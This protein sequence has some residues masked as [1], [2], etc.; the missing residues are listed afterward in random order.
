M[1]TKYFMEQ[2]FVIKELKEQPTS[3]KNRRLI[4]KA[5]KKLNKYIHIQ[6]EEQATLMYDQTVELYE[7]LIKSNLG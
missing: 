3:F 5:F 2:I 7:N 6:A 1:N 4:K